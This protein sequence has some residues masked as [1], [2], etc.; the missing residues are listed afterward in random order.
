M[1]NEEFDKREMYYFM[2]SGGEHLVEFE[3]EH[4]CNSWMCRPYDSSLCAIIRPE[5][6]KEVYAES[7]YWTLIS[8]EKY[9]EYILIKELKK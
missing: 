9:E 6:F 2:A 4:D 3:Y 7:P 1:S 5:T 8:K